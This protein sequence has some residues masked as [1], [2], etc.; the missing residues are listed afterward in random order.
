M[1][2]RLN[3]YGLWISVAALIGLLLKDLNFYPENFE[4]YVN[5]VMSILICLGFVSDPKNGMW[6]NVK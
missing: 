4:T 1:K 3:N 6:Y 5:I 2:N